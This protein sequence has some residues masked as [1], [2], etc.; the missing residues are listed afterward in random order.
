MDNKTKIC[1]LDISDDIIEFLGKQFDVYNGSL[2]AIVEFNINYGNCIRLMLNYDFPTNIHE[3]DIIIENMEKN[4]RIPYKEA[5]HTKKDII[6]NNSSYIISSYPD[7]IFNPVPCSCALLF[8]YLKEK[9]DRPIIKILFHTYKYESMYE[10][11]YSRDKS[12]FSNYQY[13]KDFTSNKISGKK[14]K[15][16]EES[17]ISNKIFDKYKSEIKYFQT[18]RHPQ[19]Y[20]SDKMKNV[21]D[22]NFV[23]LLL[24][25]NDEIISYFYKSEQD[26]TFVFPQVENKKD[27]HIGL[28]SKTHASL[29]CSSPSLGG[30]LPHKQGS[31]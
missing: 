24:N 14:V 18:Y 29:L 6:N 1:C 22:P 19:Q 13:I 7:T 21:P 27:F 17:G 12:S 8:E 10:F 5:N 28:H 26:Y 9:K 25:G 23:P 16:T 2:G 31:P 4:K 11:D 20:N 15:I 3:Y 30:A